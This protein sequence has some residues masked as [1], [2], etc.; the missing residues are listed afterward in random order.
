MVNILIL[1]DNKVGLQT[2]KKMIE[3]MTSQVQVMTAQNL[4][5]AETLLTSK[6]QLFQA[7]FLDINLDEKNED[8]QSGITFAKMV[9]SKK[10]YAFTP[11]V[12]ITSIANLEL[13]AYRELHCY[14]YI[15]KPYQE[16][17]IRKLIGKILFQTGKTTDV[18][19]TVKIEGINYK[20][21][22]KDIV[23]MKAITRGVCLVMAN[24]E[25]NVPYTSIKQMLEK[26]PKD[27]F[28]QCHRMYVINQDYID[29]VDYVNGIIKLTMCGEVEIGVTYK[30]EVRSRIDG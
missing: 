26:L 3:K 24:E 29:Y 11:I 9:R 30:N 20:I 23:Y 21:Y 5:E 15:L 18:S 1:E 12:M 28:L 17:E 2:L 25:L 22:S 16:E 8:D 14:Q 10:E 19:L 13:Q 4:E 6:N 27:R 7:F